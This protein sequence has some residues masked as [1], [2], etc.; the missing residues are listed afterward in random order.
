MKFIT[1]ATALFGFCLT[2][3]VDVSVSLH[4]EVEWTVL[5]TKL[6][7]PLSDHTASISVDDGKVY[8]AGGCGT[9]VYSFIVQALFI[10]KVREVKESHFLFQSAKLTY[11]HFAPSFPCLLFYRWS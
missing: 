6:P 7:K 3:Y 9:C 1:A 8:L 2:S 11:V 10:F 4:D 5:A